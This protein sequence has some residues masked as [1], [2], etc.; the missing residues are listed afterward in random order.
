MG[1]D[2]IQHHPDLFGFW[3][4]ISTRSFMYHGIPDDISAIGQFED[5]YFSEP[6]IFLAIPLDGITTIHLQIIYLDYL[7]KLPFHFEPHGL[8]SLMSFAFARIGIEEYLSDLM[9]RNEYIFIQI[10]AEKL[11]SPIS[12]LDLLFGRVKVD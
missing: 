9:G 4:L 5:Q 1:I 2:V 3:K 8:G 6:M 12:P 11:H 10:N 7:I